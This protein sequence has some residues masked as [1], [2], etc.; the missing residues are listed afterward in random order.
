MTV[1]IDIKSAGLKLSK[2]EKHREPLARGGTWAA[3]RV[4]RDGVAAAARD[5]SYS[6][7]PSQRIPSLH[8]DL[9]KGGGSMADA[10]YAAYSKDSSRPGDPVYHVSW[11]KSGGGSFPF[12]RLGP[13]ANRGRILISRRLGGELVWIDL[14]SLANAHPFLAPGLSR[15][16]ARARAAARNFVKKEVKRLQ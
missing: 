5:I 1:R 16:R 11:R 2:L 9:V 15:S 13:H 10:I 6:G 14:T 12:T 7:T 8:I 3:T 4:I